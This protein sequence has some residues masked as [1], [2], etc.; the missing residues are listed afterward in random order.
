MNAKIAG[1]KNELNA[2][3]VMDWHVCDAPSDNKQVVRLLKKE[4]YRACFNEYRNKD[5]FAHIENKAELLLKT[6]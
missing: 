1:C 5:W 3:L 4:L 2:P 6:D